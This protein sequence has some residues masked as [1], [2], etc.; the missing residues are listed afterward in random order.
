LMGILRVVKR[1]KVQSG[2]F[3]NLLVNSHASELNNRVSGA[4]GA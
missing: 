1:G 3:S 4:E 2:L